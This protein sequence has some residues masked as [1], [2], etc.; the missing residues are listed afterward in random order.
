MRSS[1]ICIA[2]GMCV[3]FLYKHLF[4]FF[5]YSHKCVTN[6]ELRL[7][8]IRKEKFGH[9]FQAETILRH[10]KIIRWILNVTRLPDFGCDNIF[11]Q[12][13]V[14]NYRRATN[15]VCL[16]FFFSGFE[17]STIVVYKQMAWNW[18]SHESCA[19]TNF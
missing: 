17:Y 10:R 19:D 16:H 3:P 6:S 8:C 15:F 14:S 1:V 13:I 5:S 18:Q 12:K 2:I 4:F 7:K 11:I 9:R